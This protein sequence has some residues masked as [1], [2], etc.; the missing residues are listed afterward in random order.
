MTG[1]VGQRHAEAEDALAAHGDLETAW[2]SG[3]ATADALA[4]L[5]A[6]RAGLPRYDLAALEAMTPLI[7]SLSRRYLREAHMLPLVDHQNAGVLVVADPERRE[8]IAAVRLACGRAMATAVASFE[9][10]ELLL[11]RAEGAAAPAP[12]EPEAAVTLEDSIDTLQDLARGAPIVRLI[13]QLMERAVDLGATD[14]HL[15]TERDQL[16]VRLRVDGQ[17]RAEPPLAR[18]LAP[19]VLSRIKI[20]AGLDIAERRL[21]Q[22][23]RANIRVGQTEADLRVAI[24]PTMHGETAVMR[25]LLKDNRLLDLARIG[26]GETDRAAVAALLAEPHGLLVVTGPTGSGKTTT[27]AT[28][29]A[30]LNDPARKIVTVEDPVEYQLAGVHQTQVRPAIGITFAHALRAFLRHDPDIIMVGEM[31]DRETAGIGIQAAL[32]G[33]LVLTTLHTN[34]AA[35]A[36]VRLVDLGV[37]PYLIASTLRGVLGQ[38]LVRRLCPRCA[39][40]GEPL[41]PIAARLGVPDAVPDAAVALVAVGCGACGQTGYRGRIAIFEVLK[42]DPVVRRLIREAPEPERIAAAAVAAGMTSMLADGLRKVAEGI[43]TVE[44]VVRTAG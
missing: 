30:M 39:A 7:A 27:L 42:V 31:R 26:M 29:I 2:R 15:E 36:V 32:T 4:G 38:R 8:A 3:A 12:P 16:R 9:D 41:A 11:G 23:G 13:D 6:D 35:D 1:R 34:S 43:T 40:P 33:H 10:I 20:L 37:E 44:E 17:L 28:A 24:M 5:A 25:I 19:A 22:D 18:H 14:I 21:P